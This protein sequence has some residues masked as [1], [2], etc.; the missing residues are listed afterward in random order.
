MSAALAAADLDEFVVLAGRLA[1]ASGAVA[2]R[3]FRTAVAVDE[4]SD[5]SP[6][7]IA[8]REA[9]HAIRAMIAAAYPAHGVIG[10]E[11]GNQGLRAGGGAGWVWA[12]D[13]I[14]GTKSFI[15]GRPLFG[16]L[17]ALCRDGKPVVGVIDAPMLGERWV[18]A[19]GRATLHQG[20]PVGVRACPSLDKATLCTTSPQMFSPEEWTRFERVR[21]AAK[22]PLYGGD[23]Y[24]YGLVASGF[25]DLVIETG[26]KPYDWA[27]LVPVL[28]GAGGRLT[29]WHGRPLDLASADHR[30]Q[31]VLASG[32]SRLHAAAVAL[33]SG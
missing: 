10:E 4:K 20:K 28:E 25:A 18:G 30:G 17:I 33:L 15:S 21:Q 13:P 9:E 27:A 8:D 19:A 31:R 7:T 2:R 1:D 11:H 23:C 24:S 22:I 12:I 16:T 6:V 14:D 32:D 5:R 3:Y 29:D 26:L